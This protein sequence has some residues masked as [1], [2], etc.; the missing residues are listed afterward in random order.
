MKV[1]V[2]KQW[3]KRLCTE[4]LRDNQVDGLGNEIGLSKY[5]KVLIDK[6]IALV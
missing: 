4:K 2:C 1:K 5:L 3:W 6:A